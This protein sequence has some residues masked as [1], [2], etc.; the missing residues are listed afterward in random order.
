MGRYTGKSCRLI[1]LLTVMSLFFTAEIASGYIGNSIALISDSFNMLSDIISLSVG[2]LAARVRRRNGSKRWSYGLARVE[3][4]GALANAVFLAALCFTICVQA[5][6]R[7]VS[8]EAIDKPELVLVVGSVGLGINIVGLLIFQDCRWLC[9]RT[10]RRAS[11]DTQTSVDGEA[12]YPEQTD[13]EVDPSEEDGQPLNIRGVLLH[14]LNDAMGSLVVVVTASLF[15]AWPVNNGEPCHWQCYVDPSLTLVM[16][17]IV[18]S[19]GAPL[20]KETAT[21]LLHMIPRDLNFRGVVEDVCRLHGVLSV[22]E[23]HMWELT[24]GR[25]VATFHVRVTP[26]LHSSHSGI[27]TLHRQIREVCHRVRIHSVTVQLEFGE[28]VLNGTSCSTPCLSP[29]CRK[30]SCCPADVTTLI[31]CK[32]NLS[33]YPESTIDMYDKSRLKEQ[34]AMQSISTCSSVTKF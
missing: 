15:Y 33:L 13:L 28:P 11:Q 9:R 22:H 31:A 23:A 30:I 18:M 16:V 3:V 6:K 4:V 21:I 29:S 34:E 2:L 12:G 19:S 17:A 7:L 5:L 32:A 20:V 27:I 26:D 14:V 25:Y 8:P 24:K 10:R 1:C